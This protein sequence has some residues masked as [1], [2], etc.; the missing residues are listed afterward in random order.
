METIIIAKQITLIVMIPKPASIIYPKITSSI[1]STN[2]T[3]IQKNIE[4]ID[5]IETVQISQILPHTLIIHIIEILLVLILRQKEGS[6]S[7]L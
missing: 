5:Y 1:L 3:E 2:L 7:Y 4:L 6:S